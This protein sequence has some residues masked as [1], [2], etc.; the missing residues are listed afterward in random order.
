MVRSLTVAAD[1][2]SN[3]RCAKSRPAARWNS[4]LVSFGLCNHDDEQIALPGLP[5]LSRINKFEG[6][7]TGP[8]SG[9]DLSA[10]VVNEEN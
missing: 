2:S 8:S 7:G 3:C 5:L 10:V 4:E 1:Y 9:Q 6:D